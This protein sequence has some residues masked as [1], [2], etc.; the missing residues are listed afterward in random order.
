[1]ALAELGRIGELGAFEEAV[2]WALENHPSPE[3]AKTYV[4]RIRACAH[5][6]D[7]AARVGVGG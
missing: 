6:P 1:V 3:E 4:R 7:D 5:R 2:E